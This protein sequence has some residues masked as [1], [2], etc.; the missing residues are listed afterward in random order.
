[1]ELDLDEVQRNGCGGCIRQCQDAIGHVHDFRCCDERVFCL[2][3][4]HEIGKPLASTESVPVVIVESPAATSTVYFP[5][6]S[7][8]CQLL[9]PEDP[10]RLNVAHAHPSRRCG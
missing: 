4:A 7:A 10:S 1:M 3:L 9:A 8:I 2:Q 6:G 5:S